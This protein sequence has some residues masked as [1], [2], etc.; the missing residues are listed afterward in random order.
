MCTQCRSMQRLSILQG[1]FQIGRIRYLCRSQ[2]NL[3]HLGR[4][5][6]GNRNFLIREALRGLTWFTGANLTSLLRSSS[7]LLGSKDLII[8]ETVTPLVGAGESTSESVAEQ[9]VAKINVVPTTEIR[10]FI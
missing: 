5:E 6:L 4:L 8:E 3:A 2:R 9:L 1:I 7:F 10:R